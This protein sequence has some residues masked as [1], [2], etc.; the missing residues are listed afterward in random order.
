MV[1]SPRLACREISPLPARER[2]IHNKKK[3]E[4]RWPPPLKV[5]NPGRLLHRRALVDL[6][7]VYEVDV[8]RPEGHARRKLQ[9]LALWL[10]EPGLPGHVRRYE[11][12]HGGHLSVDRIDRKDYARSCGRSSVYDGCIVHAH[13][14]HARRDLAVVCRNG[15]VE[16]VKVIQAERDR[17]WVARRRGVPIGDDER[18]ADESE[19]GDKRPR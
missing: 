13:V 8:L 1:T 5:L 2:P 12:L 16:L 6:G 18:E 15:W 10:V 7:V 4:R 3:R 14:R 11:D 17:R 9:G 19:S